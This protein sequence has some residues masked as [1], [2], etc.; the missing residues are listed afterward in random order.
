MTEKVR[1]PHP[2]KGGLDG[3]PD[4]QIAAHARQAKEI[5]QRAAQ[6]ERAAG[7]RSIYI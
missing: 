6:G 1:R 3:P 4:G 2:T 5:R 7:F